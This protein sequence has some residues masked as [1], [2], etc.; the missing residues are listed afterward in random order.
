MDLRKPEGVRTRR[1]SS[2]HHKSKHRSRGSPS[3]SPESPRRKHR[4]SRHDDSPDLKRS[5]ASK[6][7]KSADKVVAN[8]EKTEDP[9]DF[10]NFPEICAASRQNLEKRGITKLFPVQY[11]TF[12]RITEHEDLMVRDLTG[13]GKTLGFC[14]PMVE[15]FRN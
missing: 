1:D 4:S 9:G 14:L 13:S 2:D 15:M 3:K 5:K 7:D 10:S 11:M 12:K 8:P 6:T